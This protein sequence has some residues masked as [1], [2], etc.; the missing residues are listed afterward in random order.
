MCHSS[1]L[2]SEL[3]SQDQTIKFW[4]L[5]GG[6]MIACPFDLAASS[7]NAQGITY[8]QTDAMGN[9]VEYT[10]PCGAP[11]PPGR[12]AHAIAWLEAMCRPAA[13]GVTIGTPF[14]G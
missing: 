6:E 11:I 4:S 14:S 3:G 13:A 1:L 9:L 5:P 12:F 2:V 10:L 8:Q 7:E